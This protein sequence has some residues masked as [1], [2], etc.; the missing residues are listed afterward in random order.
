MSLFGLYIRFCHL[1]GLICSISSAPPLRSRE[2]SLTLGWNNNTIITTV[3]E[4]NHLH[5][6]KAKFKIS[7]F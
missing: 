7:T 5:S 2:L 1:F 3:A 6:G 4:I